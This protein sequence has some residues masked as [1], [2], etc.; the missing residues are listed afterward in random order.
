MHLCSG[1]SRLY[2]PLKMSP[3]M[4]SSSSL[5][6]TGRMMSA[7]RQ[8]FSSHGCWANMNSMSGWRMALT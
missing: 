1:K 4:S 8:S 3:A 5:V 6:F 2:W 7:I